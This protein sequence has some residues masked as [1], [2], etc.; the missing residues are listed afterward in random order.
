MDNGASGT[1]RSNGPK[2]CVA[3]SLMQSTDGSSVL[4]NSQPLPDWDAPQAL[5]S[6]SS[7][8]SLPVRGAPNGRS[9]HTFA[10]GCTGQVGRDGRP[11]A[12]FAPPQMAPDVTEP[13]RQHKEHCCRGRLLAVDDGDVVG[14]RHV[15]QPTLREYQKT[16]K[17]LIE[18]GHFDVETLV[19]RKSG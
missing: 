2:T 1:P 8:E 5:V 19:S 12:A 7:T 4:R 13:R 17:L 9:Q 6:A 11:K 18:D 3:G 10:I 15:A 14:M 16:G